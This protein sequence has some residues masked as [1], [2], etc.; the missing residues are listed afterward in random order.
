MENNNNYKIQLKEKQMQ[1]LNLIYKLENNILSKMNNKDNRI[2]ELEKHTQSNYDIEEYKA[3]DIC[4]GELMD[5]IIIHGLSVQDVVDVFAKV[6]Y[7]IEGD[8]LVQNMEEEKVNRW[9]W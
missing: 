6:M 5:A 9:D 1:V 3:N 2:I 4:V 7:E 8:E